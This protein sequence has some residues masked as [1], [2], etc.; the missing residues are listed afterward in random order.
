VIAQSGGAKVARSFGIG[1]AIQA[2]L[3]GANFLVGLIL[4]RGTTETQ[5]GYYVLTTNTLL[6]FTSLQTAFIQP[7]IVTSL[8]RMD[9]EARRGMIGSLVRIAR[10][11]IPLVCAVGLGVTAAIWAAGELDQEQ[12]LIVAVGVLAAGAAMNREFLRVS[13]F[14]YRRP[15]EVLRGDLTYV[16]LLI[17]G[18]VAATYTTQAAPVAIAS[19]ALAAILGRLVL[20]HGLWRHEP[21]NPHFQDNTLRKM[22]TLGAW[23]ILGSGIHWLLIQGYGYLVAG[24]LNIRYV[25]AIAATRLMLVPVFVLSGGVS[26]LLFPIT[27]RWVHDMGT[28]TA[29]RRLAMLVVALALVAVAYMAAMWVMRDWIFT[30]ILKKQFEQR[31]VLLLLWSAVF[32]VTLCRDQIATLPAAREKFR[33]MTLMTCASAAIWLVSSYWAIQHFGAPGAV[34]GILIGETINMLGLVVLIFREIRLSVVASAP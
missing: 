20:S 19:L 7:Y 18:A 13:L 27:S 4:I 23:A 6:L 21:W 33:D 34:L 9:L 16:G 29:A 14:A 24:L 5:Y 2:L 15:M 32:L 11:W 31:D 10:R 8:T 12:A 25:A 22:A 17:V 28:T 3:S 30:T 26:M 1:L